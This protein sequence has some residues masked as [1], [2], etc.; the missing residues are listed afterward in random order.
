M[1]TTSAKLALSAL[2]L[3]AVATLTGC[4]PAATAPAGEPPVSL[5][6][7]PGQQGLKQVV[8]AGDAVTKV[9][10]TTQPLAETVATVNGVSGSHKVI[11]YSAV[12]YHTDGSTWTFVETAARTFVRQPITVAEVQGQIAV[13]TA[14]PQVGAKVVTVGAPELLGAEYGISGEQ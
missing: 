11:P 4:G 2:A 6:A 1:F 7:V 13:L 3:T 12:V 8:L 10:I 14:G 5:A 9:G